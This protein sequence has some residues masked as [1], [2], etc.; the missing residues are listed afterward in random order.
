[1][2]F[3]S[4]FFLW[5]A[6]KNAPLKNNARTNAYIFAGICILVASLA[7]GFLS[8]LA[9]V[10]SLTELPE[11]ARLENSRYNVDKPENKVNEPIRQEEVNRRDSS[12]TELTQDTAT[13]ASLGNQNQAA[14]HT[15]ANSKP[16]E[17]LNPSVVFLHENA[18]WIAIL[19]GFFVFLLI[20]LLLRFLASIDD[21]VKMVHRLLWWC[22]GANIKVLDE[23]PTE[24]AKYYGIGGTI[25]F[26]AL[27]ASFAGGYAFFTAFHN[28][29]LSIF[30]GLFWGALIF[31]LD[32]YIVSSTG[33]GDGTSKIT[34]DEWIS[35]SPRL[36]LA[37]IIGFVISTPL[38]L[39]IFE[40]EINVEMQ[41][42]I[43]EERTNIKGGLTD[44]RFE[45]Q[46][47]KDRIAELDKELENIENNVRG[48]DVILESGN[49]DL[50]E[51]RREIAQLR[52]QQNRA[53]SNYVDTRNSAQRYE[54][55]VDRG[56]NIEENR[57]RQRSEEARMRSYERQVSDYRDR[58][59]SQEARERDII[60]SN[61]AR[62][63]VLRENLQNTE[64]MVMN[65]K[66]R[67]NA[68]IQELERRLASK[69]TE[70]DE[71]S[72]QFNGLMARLIALERLSSRFDTTYSEASSVN[73]MQVPNQNSRSDTSTNISESPSVGNTALA[74]P[75]GRQVVKIRESKTPVFYAKWMIALLIICIEIAPI[76]FKMMTEAGTYDDR[77]AEIAYQ[78]DVQKKK[79]ISDINE[80]INTELK[81]SNN[82]N[83][84]KIN[85]ELK[86]NQD[87]VEAIANAQAEIA[88]VAIEEWKKKQIETVMN[89]PEII[90]KARIN[91]NGEFGQ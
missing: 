52:S 15:T 1:M 7:I 67:I 47:R 85:A 38:E 57:R 35:A 75:S 21:K 71:V 36:V 90:V 53:M 73:K 74:A 27:M 20:F 87:L 81:I 46:G 5:C 62:E 80:K 54:S 17:S 30:F 91:G 68:E 12:N 40:R 45:I 84:N 3:I 82:S 55:L 2:N 11:R 4:N 72:T 76:L 26:T 29:P 78:S 66:N 42:M 16:A 64:E 44:L 14:T 23:C 77:L 56:I 32:R 83:Q 33:I 31:N 86:A 24:H 8:S 9:T 88:M 65:E 60:R 51:V 49:N 37:L 43:N 61:D 50:A 79:F 18:D 22:A 70:A 25:V 58:L 41:K 19:V 39:K 89:Q 28:I 34:K 63:T 69:N 10:D 13:T 48:G 6:G 59:R